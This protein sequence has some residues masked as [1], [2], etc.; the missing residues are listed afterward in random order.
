[1]WRGRCRLVSTSAMA[2]STPR[3]CTLMLTGL[4]VHTLHTL[5]APLQATV[6]CSVKT[7][8]PSRQSD[9][10]LCHSRVPRPN[11]GLWHQFVLYILSLRKGSIHPAMVVGT[12]ADRPGVRSVPAWKF[13]KSNTNIAYDIWRSS[14]YLSFFVKLVCVNFNQSRCHLNA[15]IDIGRAMNYIRDILFRSTLDTC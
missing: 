1:M 12:W 15:V 13:Q 2:L 11:I 4:A 6:F 5:D 10:P 9:R 14:L 3:W 8:C 7:S